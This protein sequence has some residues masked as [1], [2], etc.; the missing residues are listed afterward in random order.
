MTMI[1][2]HV[3]NRKLIF[4]L[5]AQNFKKQLWYAKQHDND[6]D[7][8]YMAMF[9]EYMSCYFVIKKTNLENMV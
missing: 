6:K 7:S 9:K 5:L 1:K 8:M 2:L 4:T 3:F